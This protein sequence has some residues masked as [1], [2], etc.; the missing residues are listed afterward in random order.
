MYMKFQKI[1]MTGSR[2]MDKKHQKCPENEG[3]PPFMT[4][5]FFFK[6]RALLLLYPYGALTSCQK[7]EKTNGQSQRYLKTDRQKD[8]RTGVIT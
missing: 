4:P 2:D 5:R 7:L 3:L 8:R 1:L 6:N